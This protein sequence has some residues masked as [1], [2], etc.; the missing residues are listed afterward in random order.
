MGPAYPRGAL[1]RQFSMS[2]EATPIDSV[3]IEHSRR[4]FVFRSVSPDDHIFRLMVRTKRFYEQDVLDRLLERLAVSRAQ[5]ASIDA[6]AFIGTHSVFFGAVLGL[7]PVISFEANPQTFPL[8][9]ENLQANGP[10]EQFIPI[11]AALGAREG[12]VTIELGPHNNRGAT[13][14]LEADDGKG[15]IPVVTLD[16]ELGR[17]AIGKIALLKVDV[18]GA[19]LAVL[20]GAVRTLR[21]FRPLLCIEVHTARH[22]AEV[23]RRVEPLGYCIIDCLGFSPTYILE[24]RAGH[25]IQ[26]A[27]VNRVWLL[28]AAASHKNWRLKLYT[29]RLAQSLSTG[30]W[31]PPDE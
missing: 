14:M 22:L 12:R 6:G 19:E 13:R 29:R 4:R 28:R 15:E 23:L 2:D 25:L 18:E 1:P 3:T 24:Y 30:R 7:Y 21:D 27:I 11:N 16:Q 26:N 31:D 8:L 5:G 17:L 20:D 9:Q 10:T